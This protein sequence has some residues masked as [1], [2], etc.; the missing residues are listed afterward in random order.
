MRQAQIQPKNVKRGGSWNW[1]VPDA[2]APVGSL[3][4]PG[5]PPTD[6]LTIAFG[7][8]C[9][10]PVL[11]A[12]VARL[13]LPPQPMTLAVRPSTVSQITGLRTAQTAVLMFGLLT[14]PTSLHRA[15]TPVSPTG[16]R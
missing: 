15:R 9:R 5:P 11:W 14:A 3:A 13:W 16:R 6:H 8:M 7:S 12:G 10:S 4:A 2:Q 1:R